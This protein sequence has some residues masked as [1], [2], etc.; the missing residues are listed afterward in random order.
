MRSPC[1]A[2]TGVHHRCNCI[3]GNAL[4]MRL[5]PSLLTSR[6]IIVAPRLCFS[7]LGATSALTIGR[8]LKV[9][10]RTFCGVWLFIL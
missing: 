6:G 8:D 4:A 3:P 2:R 5:L 1:A 10:Y 7:S 9:I